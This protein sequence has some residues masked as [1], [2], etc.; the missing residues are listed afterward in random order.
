MSR[1]N[2]ILMS[3]L[4]TDSYHQEASSPFEDAPAALL[5]PPATPS[6]YHRL[7]T[8]SWGLGIL[9]WLVATLLLIA[10]L[11]VFREYDQRALSQWSSRLSL[12]T[13]V[14]IVTQL[15]QMT[16]L[17]PIA[18]GISQLKWLW[19]CEKKPVEDMSYFQEGST[20]PIS[21]FILLFKH[22]AS[23]FVWSICSASLVASYTSN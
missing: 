4:S 12:N 11:I 13:I 16:L 17:L 23:L 8:D 9:G 14:A 15:A 21:S 7:V 5:S 19:Y 3:E 22:R 20:G 6:F 10:L 1:A 2:S 18:E